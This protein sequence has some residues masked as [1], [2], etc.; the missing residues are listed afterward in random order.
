MSAPYNGGSAY[1]Q[2]NTYHANGEIEYGSVGISI[3]TAIA[4]DVLAALM[5]NQDVSAAPDPRYVEFSVQWA[6]A[7]IAEL[8]KGGG[9]L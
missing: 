7:L 6:D 4:K 1:P 5:H 8:T 9:V 3:R 2:P